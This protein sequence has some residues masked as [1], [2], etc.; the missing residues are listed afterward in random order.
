MLT[1][2]G[3][4][5]VERCVGDRATRSRILGRLDALVSAAAPDDDCLVYYFGHGGRVRFPE[6]PPPLDT[7]TFGYVTVHRA[8]RGGPFEAVLDRELSTRLTALDAR[9]GNVTAILDC[10]FSGELVRDGE[11]HPS[12]ERREPVHDWVAEATATRD[13]ALAVDSHP[14][15][16]RITGASP[17]REA[18]AT[19]RSGRHIG[20]LTEGLLAVLEDA[21]DRWNELTWGT[22]GH[23][24]REHVIGALQM[25]GQWIN[26][27]GPRTRRVFGRESAALPGTVPFVPG[28]E[29]GRGWLRAGWHQGVSVGDRWAILDAR[30]GDE[31][32][33][34]LATAHVDAVERN[35]AAVVVEGE[36]E[37]A[38]GSPAHPTAVHSP[39]PVAVDDET[40][41]D[42]VEASAW[43]TT[44]PEGAVRVTR[45]EAGLRIDDEG[46][47]PVVVPDAAQAIAVLEDRARLATLLATLGE[48]PRSRTPVQWSWRRIGETEPRPASG[49][50]LTAGD[51]IRI[52]LRFES[53]APLHW[54]VSVLYADPAGRLHLL[55]ARMPEG[56]ELGPG[57]RD[58]IGVRLDRDSQGL[59]LPWPRGVQADAAPASLIVLASRRPMPLEHLATARPADDDEAFAL[60]GMRAETL[61]SRAPE[62]TKACTHDRIDFTLHRGDPPDA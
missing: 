21:G 27:A 59:P 20:R 1:K 18:Y 3:F 29:A 40:L 43:L 50:E 26:V 46:R 49:S 47:P 12:D 4:G 24:V 13:D 32:P 9:C 33:R 62:H 23:R 51:R 16:V 15:I 41:R 36:T 34:V 6:L 35:R 22:L 10:C 55:N 8:V 54:F 19:E 31:G 52:D 39:L 17:K 2:L 7:H 14:R 48:H 60:Q 5:R 44:S 58:S 37:L 53:R 61:R 42:A 38:P 57:S 56:I 30:I 28:E 11:P 25:E 45:D